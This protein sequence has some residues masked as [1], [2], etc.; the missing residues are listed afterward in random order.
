[1]WLHEVWQK[2]LQQLADYGNKIGPRGQQTFE[3]VDQGF[4]IDSTYNIL[5]CP[6]RKMNYRFAVAEW[7]WMTFGRSDVESIARYNSVMRQFSDD[8]I[9]MTG[10]YGPHIKAQY[11][12]VL[13]KLRRDPATRQAVIEIPRPRRET[14]DEPCTLSMQFLLRGG[15]LHQIVTMRSSDIWLGVPYDVF[16]FTMFQNAFAAELGCARGW[17][18][19]HAGSRHLYER[20]LSAANAAVADDYTTTLPSPN[21]PGLPPP[22]LERV[23][24]EGS[25]ADLNEPVHP[26]WLA[27]AAVLMS[28]TSEEARSILMDIGNVRD[29][30]L[31]T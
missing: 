11:R 12:G 14:K 31:H 20:D 27:Y 23:L 28:K 16:T 4:V 7:I 22:F 1:M 18:S 21:L 8:G 5:N 24:M 19:L 2:E 17:L 6:A 10:A 9:W 30:S 26:L 29:I 13:D 25:L 3:F 15:Q